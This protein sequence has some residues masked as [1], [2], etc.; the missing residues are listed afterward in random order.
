MALCG[1]AIA[2]VAPTTPTRAIA[3][4]LSLAGAI[5]LVLDRR[6]GAATPAPTAGATPDALARVTEQAQALAQG[7]EL[8]AARD[9][10]ALDALHQVADKLNT[11]MTARVRIVATERD[12]EQARRM[13]RQILP[14]A[15]ATTHNTLALAGVCKPAA[16]TGGDWWAYRK[17][18]DGTLVLVIGDATGHGVH[19]AMVGCM[20][21]GA[22]K[23][24]DHVEGGHANVRGVVDAVLA[25]I[26]IPGVQHAPMTLFAATIHPTTGDIQYV[27][28]GH[29]FPL[30]GERDARG[31]IVRLRSITGETTDP[32]GESFDSQEIGMRTGTARLAAGD[33]LV[34]FTDGLIERAKDNGRPFGMRRLLGVL[35]N[36]EVAPG[37]DGLATLR[38]RILQKVEDYAEGS[39]VDDDVTIVLCARASAA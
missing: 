14:L 5:V 22:M 39:A 10:P 24:L 33:L 19:S 32:D 23:A 18:A 7:K 27:N 4:A 37:A 8:A 29:V 9:L 35:T 31:T 20:A 21:H 11:M 6:G 26:R 34:C 13:Y 17:L 30:I 36:A 12:L 38:D 15:S 1:A 2:L 3:A 28:H 16:E 25:A